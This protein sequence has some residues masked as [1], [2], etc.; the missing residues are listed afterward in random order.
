MVWSG[1]GLGTLV[2]SKLI[3]SVHLGLVVF[4]SVQFGPIRSD[5]V[6]TSWSRFILVCT[7]WSGQV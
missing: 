1:I 2:L 4:R 5:L 3:C 6:C 7:L